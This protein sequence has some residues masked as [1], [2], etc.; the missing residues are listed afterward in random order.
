MKSK[1]LFLELNLPLD[2]KRLSWFG[3]HENEKTGLFQ[4]GFAL[5]F[6]FEHQ[7]PIHKGEAILFE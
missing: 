3:R 5:S 2:K 1:C 6:S 4:T 7:I